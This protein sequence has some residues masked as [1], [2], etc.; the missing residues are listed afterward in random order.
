MGL[1][2]PYLAWYWTLHL[3]TATWLD[4]SWFSYS[5]AGVWSLVGFSPN[6]LR[7]QRSSVLYRQRSNFQTWLA[8]SARLDS[9][10]SATSAYS[11]Y[12]ACAGR[13]R[14][15]FGWGSGL[16]AM[17]CSAAWQPSDALRILNVPRCNGGKLT[18]PVSH[19]WRP[20]SW[21]TL[22]WTGVDPPRSWAYPW[23]TCRFGAFQGQSTSSR[24]F[25]HCH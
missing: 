19:H 17:P 18:R 23:L 11:A 9:S 20:N 8:F 6:L 2:C 1:Q 3:R 13:S 25:A 4:Y 5:C 14:R 22:Y 10:L 7:Q 24:R 21:C 15:A 12:Q 16:H